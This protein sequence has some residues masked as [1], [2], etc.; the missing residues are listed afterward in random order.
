MGLYQEGFTQNREISWLRYNERVLEEALDNTVPLFERLKYVG[1]FAS[2]LEEFVKVRVGGLIQE[3]DNGSDEIDV[4]SGMNVEQ[5]LNKIHHET[6]NMIRR[7]NAIHTQVEGELAHAGIIRLNY[8]QLTDEEK[9]R[10]DRFFDLEVQPELNTTIIHSSDIWKYINEFK[11]YIIVRIQSD[12]ADKYALIDIPETLKKIFVLSNG[13]KIGDKFRY[14]LVEDII[15]EHVKDMFFPFRVSE[16]HYFDITRNAEVDVEFSDNLLNDMKNI[17]KAR[18]VSAPDCL[19]VDSELSKEMRLFFEKELELVS[20]QIIV[21][22]RTSYSYIDEL[23]EML[24]EWL[25]N[26]VLYEHYEPFNQLQL[27]FGSVIDRVQKE[28]ILSSY[29]YDSMKPFLELLREASMHEDVTE[30][31]ITIYRLASRPLIVSY[32]LQAARNGKKV[33]V[34][35]ELRARF[36][37]AHNIDWAEKLK[38]GGCEVY[39]GAGTYKVHSKICQVVMKNRDGK[40]RYITQ[41][42]TGNYNESTARKYTDFSL[43]TYDQ[44]I[45]KSAN[46]FFKDLFKVKQREYKH[47]KASPLTMRSEIMRLIKRETEKGRKGRIFIKVNS[48]TDEKII[49]AL[50]E[51]SCAGCQIKMIVRGICCILPGIE[52]YT[53]NIEIVNVV[54][55]LLEHSRVYL[56]GMGDD[57]VMYI[58]SADLMNRNMNKRVEVACPIYNGNIRERIKAVLYLNFMDNVKGRILGPDGKYYKKP[59]TDRLIDS[60]KML[61]EL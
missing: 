57:E 20:S 41:V 37:E 42:G 21:S 46:K 26:V 14:I 33:S 28:D 40:N 58:S 34:C 60:Q 18:E 23:E 7:M 59:A 31:R 48:V 19:T 54:G 44:K 9:K 22:P 53:E 56:F 38:A 49:E 17:V 32:L 45:G 39:Y 13:T 24:P 5:Q 50:M 52:G 6:S 51:A 2:N 35:M 30:I 1:I 29:P 8:G 47:I 11:T 27:G 25:R 61:M 12:D 10:L 36:D 43:I 15:R 4:R 3:Y 55:R 16:Y